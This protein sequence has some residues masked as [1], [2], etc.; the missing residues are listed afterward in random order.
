MKWTTAIVFCALCGCG[1]GNAHPESFED[2]DVET[3]SRRVLTADVTNARDLGGWPVAGGVVECSRILRGGALAKLSEK[4]CHELAELG[5]NTIVDLRA[6][7]VQETTPDS[8]CATQSTVHIPVPM[9]KL[10][11]DTPEN[12]LALLNETEAIRAVFAALRDATSYPVYLHCEIGRDRASFIT[13]LIL[14]ALGATQQTVLE[15]FMLSNEAGVA[16]KAECLTA[17]LDEINRRG[18]IEVFLSA[19]GVE[20]PTIDALRRNALEKEEGQ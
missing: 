20:R 7:A 16:V 11:P 19:S 14:L 1:D 6:Q 3:C 8:A 2:S 10:L 9:P 17:V 15:E 18:G 12:Y 5:V 4:G 13:A